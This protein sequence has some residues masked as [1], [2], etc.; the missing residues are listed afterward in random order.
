MI[1]LPQISS[2]QKTPNLTILAQ[3]KEIQLPER[4]LPTQNISEKQESLLT[5]IGNAIS[6]T[7]RWSFFLG[8]TYGLYRLGARSNKISQLSVASIE[9]LTSLAVKIPLLNKNSFLFDTQHAAS[10][11][12]LSLQG[13]G[14]QVL[15]LR[16]ELDLLL[17]KK[18][19]SQKVFVPGTKNLDGLVQGLGVPYRQDEARLPL[20]LKL[21]HG[22]VNPDLF[23]RPSEYTSGSEFSGNQGLLTRFADAKVKDIKGSIYVARAAKAL[24]F[25]ATYFALD[26]FVS[27][28]SISETDS[29]KDESKNKIERPVDYKVYPG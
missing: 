5:K 19:P 9:K 8:T 13:G 22:V 26:R 6:T 29:N 24:L 7:I 20:N 23:K 16:K 18:M 4:P 11:A 21:P 25:G 27:I 1:S 14:H 17:A 10:T 15:K 12:K 28:F 2:T 3:N